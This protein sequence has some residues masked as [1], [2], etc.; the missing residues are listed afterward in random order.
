MQPPLA[1]TLGTN[2]NLID[3]DSRRPPAI[4]GLRV[5]DH[6]QYRLTKNGGI[7]KKIQAS[8]AATSAR[9]GRSRGFSR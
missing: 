7:P 6:G 1:A 2:S 8:N 5:I 9:V 4:L 3:H